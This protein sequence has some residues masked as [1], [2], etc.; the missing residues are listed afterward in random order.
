MF[1]LLN[2]IYTLND[3]FE[4][5]YIEHFVMFLINAIYAHIIITLNRVVRVFILY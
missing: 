1:V 2:Y 5:S 3:L 4:N